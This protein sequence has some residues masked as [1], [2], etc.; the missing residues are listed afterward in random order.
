MANRIT[1]KG[2]VP[3]ESWADVFRCFVSQGVRLIPKK[4]KLGIDFEL[5]FADGQNVKADDPAVK[6]MEEAARQ[7]GLE[8]EIE[9]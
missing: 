6:A 8:M 4:L 2:S 9:E 3:A 1:I 5:L 7:L